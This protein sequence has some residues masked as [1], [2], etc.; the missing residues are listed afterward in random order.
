MRAIERGRGD[1][2]TARLWRAA[3]HGSRRLTPSVGPKRSAKAFGQSVRIESKEHRATIPATV[4]GSCYYEAAR[5][6]GAGLTHSARY[7]VN[8]S[9][10]DKGTWP[11]PIS[12]LKPP[13]TSTCPLGRRVAAFS[14][15]ELVIE[16]PSG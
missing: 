11:N 4:R 16:A 6:V 9:A 12:Y 7:G 14:Y 8:S 13:E 3:R 15:R 2:G 1:G 10:L 5:C